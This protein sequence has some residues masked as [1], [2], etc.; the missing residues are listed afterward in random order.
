[1]DPLLWG[2]CF[3]K[4]L[5]SI[6]FNCKDDDLE[7]ITK[8]LKLLE[9]V[10]PC[11]TCR[12]HYAV[13]RQEC[14]K[15][16]PLKTSTKNLSHWLWHM[17]SLVNK[18]TKKTNTEYKY[19][20]QRYNVFGHDVC[21]TEVADVLMLMTLY[22]EKTYDKLKFSEFI[23]CLGQLLNRF[24]PCQLSALLQCI[25]NTDPLVMLRLV[26]SVRFSNKQ[27]SRE[28]KHYISLKL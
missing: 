5:F 14:D 12:T 28:L 2:P 1:M 27:Q 18:N 11:P 13:N 15:S 6:S 8:L 7:N 24:M 3:W 17:K 9:K 25:D 26:N 10:I 20:E 19:I 22:L 23:N 4:V 21:E 16:F